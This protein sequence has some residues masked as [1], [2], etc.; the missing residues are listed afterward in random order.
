MARRRAERHTRRE[1]LGGLG[2]A[3]SLG[4]ASATLIPG[5]SALGAR[6]PPSVDAAI[7]GGGI[8]GLAC[9][10]TLQK[11]GVNATIYEARHRLGGRIWSLAAP[12]LARSSFLARWRNAVASSSTPRI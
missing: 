7:V 3:A 8:A 5:R 1:F 9:A 4:L 6:R 10:D 2:K 12:F 11:A